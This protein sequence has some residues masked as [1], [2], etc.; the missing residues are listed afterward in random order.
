LIA[1]NEGISPEKEA[2][3]TAP[4]TEKAPFEQGGKAAAPGFS[5]A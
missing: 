1:K 5:G 2:R 3:E 4:S